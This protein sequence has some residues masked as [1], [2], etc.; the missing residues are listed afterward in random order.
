MQV[1]LTRAE[2]LKSKAAFVPLRKLFPLIT[3]GSVN[4]VLIGGAITPPSP[5]ML[6]FAATAGITVTIPINIATLRSIAVILFI[7]ILVFIVLRSLI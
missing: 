1:P 7:F 3:H 2:I 4:P 6:V 5:H